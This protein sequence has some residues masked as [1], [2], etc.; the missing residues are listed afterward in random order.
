MRQFKKNKF[1]NR[2]L[3]EKEELKQ[4]LEVQRTIIEKFTKQKKVLKMKKIILRAQKKF[5]KNLKNGF[6]Q[7]KEM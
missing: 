5:R 6:L 7:I 1:I 4:I 2:E 3:E